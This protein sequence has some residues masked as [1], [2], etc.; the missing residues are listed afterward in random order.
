[1]EPEVHCSKNYIWTI[2]LSTFLGGGTYGNVIKGHERRTGKYVAIKIFKAPQKEKEP[3]GYVEEWNVLRDLESDY[4]VRHIAMEPVSGKVDKKALVME[5]A[6][7]TVRNELDM[8]EH[9]FGLPY[10][11]LF[12]IIDHCVEALRYLDSLKIAHRDIKPDNILV[13]R[14][15]RLTFKL[16]DFGGARC[17]ENTDQPMNESVGTSGYIMSTIVK[18]LAAENDE[19]TYTKDQHDIWASTTCFFECATGRLPFRA[20]DAR[21]EYKSIAKL[22]KERPKGIVCGD[23]DYATKHN[24]YQEEMPLQH[25]S[26]SRHLR[27]ILAEFF[28]KMFDQEKAFLHFDIFYVLC[29]DLTSLKCYKYYNISALRIDEYFDTSRSKHFEK[30]S[31]GAE[32]VEGMR[33][34]S[35]EL[36]VRKTVSDTDLQIMQGFQAHSNVS[37]FQPRIDDSHNKLVAW[38]SKDAENIDLMESMSPLLFEPR[39]VYAAETSVRRIKKAI[40]NDA[41][42][43]LRIQMEENQMRRFF[44]SIINICRYYKEALFHRCANDTEAMTIFDTL[45]GKFDQ[46]T[47]LLDREEDE[48]MKKM[49]LETDDYEDKTLAYT[50][51]LSENR[52]ISELSRKTLRTQELIDVQLETSALRGRSE[53]LSV[54]CKLVQSELEDARKSLQTTTNYI[55]NRV[56][57][58]LGPELLQF[59]RIAKQLHKSAAR[60][61]E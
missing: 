27:Q 19:L 52:K 15:P 24:T 54:N 18:N 45:L 4:I 60:D 43:V 28:R 10:P 26:Y 61:R 6:D 47:T 55:R 1:M 49:A 36:Q 9:Y 25:H 23:T 38:Q 12:T 29:H 34:L 8:Q 20:Q 48:T 7:G 50:S 13:F 58:V 3:K 16:C 5:L 2:R 41:A 40:K 33:N 22:F 11:T 42:L 37:S 21:G 35:A 56:Y 53:L 31:F 30:K 46:C 44:N 32:V 59:Y 39:F 17:L 51:I 14:R 57:K